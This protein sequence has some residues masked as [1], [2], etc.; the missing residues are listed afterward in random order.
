[1][2]T[3][4]QEAFSELL[5]ESWSCSKMSEKIVGEVSLMRSVSV[6]FDF[7]KCTELSLKFL[8][9]VHCCAFR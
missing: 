7:N 6:A 2:R 9:L 1:M 8:C 4:D 5:E 3:T